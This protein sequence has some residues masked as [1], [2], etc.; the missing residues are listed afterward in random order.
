MQVK[1]K[2]RLK[3]ST[4][5]GLKVLFSIVLSMV[6]IWCMLQSYHVEQK[7]VKPILNIH[8]KT[9][10]DYQ[11]YL[12]KNEYYNVPY[13]N[14]GNLYIT[15]MIDFIQMKLNYQFQA[16]KKFDYTYQYRVVATLFSTK[17]EQKIK[18]TV[19]SKSYM[20]K[21]T[22]K[23]EQKN[24]DSFMLED[25]IKVPFSTYLEQVKKIG[26]KYQL[27]SNLDIRVYIDVVGSTSLYAKK[28]VSNEIMKISAPMNKDTIAIQTDYAK[29]RTQPVLE[30]TE[31]KKEENKIIF[32]FSCIAFAIAITVLE[33]SLLELWN[34]TR[35]QFSYEKEK[36]KILN[37]Y[38]SIIVNAKKLPSMAKKEVIE[39]TSIEELSD[40]A[41]ELHLPIIYIEIIPGSVSWFFILN[42]KQVWRY[43]LRQ[44]KEGK[45]SRK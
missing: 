20:L 32:L 34:R 9:N 40:A 6:S 21:T 36:K 23:V 43:I 27:D 7:E 18:R 29:E 41:S 1:K 31:I 35:V 39:V 8:S 45:E 2:R 25:V 15:S 17:E 16:S 11:V 42:K 24:A 38:D 30:I 22:Q 13:L 5:S 3:K 33:M 26:T 14:S 37:K 28:I 19:W 12:K 10:L 44:E 4:I